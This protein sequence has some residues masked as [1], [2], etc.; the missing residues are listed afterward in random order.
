MR[1]QCVRC[2][3]GYAVGVTYPRR[4]MLEVG[5]TQSEVECRLPACQ[6]CTTWMIRRWKEAP[7][8]ERASLRFGWETIEEWNAEK[9]RRFQEQHA[10]M[11]NRE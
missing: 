6:M 8:A 2:K 1:L 5:M 9:R 10:K 7:V 4:R 3:G 11:F